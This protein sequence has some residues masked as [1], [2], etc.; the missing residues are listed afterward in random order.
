MSDDDN[1]KN[2]VDVVV[3]L[4]NN[5]K[6]ATAAIASILSQIFPVR[7]VIIVD[8]GSSDRSA[9]IVEQ[10]FAHEPR[11]KLVR[12]EHRGA[13]ATRNRGIA[14]SDAEFIAF[15][16][17]DDL[18]DPL[19]LELQMAVL[20]HN[21][22]V[23]CVYCDYRIMDENGNIVSDAYVL[24]PTLQGDVFSRL[25]TGNLLSGS[26]SAIVVRRSL[27]RRTGLFD[28]SLA[29]AE[30]WDMWLRL[31]K[32]SEIRFV[33]RPLTFIRVH[34]SQMQANA[35]K[36]R[37]AQRMHRLI[38]HLRIWSKWPD[39]VSQHD[40]VLGM[41]R[42]AFLKPCLTTGQS[43][44]RRLAVLR[45]MNIRTGAYIHRRVFR[46]AFKSMFHLYAEIASGHT[47]L[48]LAKARPAEVGPILFAFRHYLS[49]TL[50]RLWPL[51]RKSSASAGLRQNEGVITGV[52][53]VSVIMAVYNGA[54]FVRA[55]IDSIL[56]QTFTDFELIVVDDG[57]TDT[58]AQILKSIGDPRLRLVRQENQGLAA[59]LNHAISLAR[60]KYLARHDHDDVSLPQ[61]FAKQVAFLD[62]HP[63]YAL[64]G[65]H[66]VIW[67]GDQPTDRG[68]HHP[69]D[70]PA[71]RFQLLFDSYFVHGSV[72]L[73]REAVVALGGYTLD[74]SRQPPEDYELWSRIVRH[75]KVAN[76]A[77]PLL[78][79]REVP[80]SISRTVNFKDK[81]IT[82]SSENLA[83]AAGLPHPNS[84]TQDIAAIVHHEPC[85]LSGCPNFARMSNIIRQAAR[86]IDQVA[87]GGDVM[88]R[89]ETLIDQLKGKWPRQDEAKPRSIIRLM[90]GIGNQFFQYLFG[91]SRAATLSEQVLFDAGDCVDMNAVRPFKLSRF[92][93]AGQF[94][95]CSARH[96]DRS[97][98]ELE[99]VTNLEGDALGETIHMPARREVN[100]AVSAE[101]P[102]APGYY[103]GYWQ[104]YK[105]WD[106][107]FDIVSDMLAAATKEVAASRAALYQALSSPDAV[108]VH[109]RRGDYTSAFN[110]EYH[111]VCTAEYYVRAV[112]ELQK[113]LHRPRL[114][115]FGDD[116]PFA[117]EL[118]AAIPDVRY[119]SAEVNDDVDEFLLL[120]QA[121]NLVMS[122]SS[123]SYIAAMNRNA[124]TK[125]VMAPYP[126][127]TFQEDMPDYPQH[128]VRRN[129]KSG[130]SEAEDRALIASARVS[131]IIPSK[132]RDQLLPEAIKTAL[133]QTHEPHEV[134]VSLNGATAAVRS[135]AEVCRQ[136]DGRVKIVEDSRSSLPVARNNG[137]KAATGE[138]LAFLDDDDIWT[139][140]KIER[141]VSAA[142]MMGADVVAC[143]YYKFNEKERWDP[144]SLSSAKT[145]TWSE[146]LTIGN[147]FGGGSSVLARANAIRACGGF[148]EALRSCEDQDMWRRLALSGAALLFID[149][150]L[151]GYRIA[152]D[153]M[154]GD[155]RLMLAG[156][157]AHLSEIIWDSR[158][159]SATASQQATERVLAPLL[160]YLVQLQD[161]QV[162]HFPS[163]EWEIDLIGREFEGNLAAV[164]AELHKLR[165][166]LVSARSELEDTRA[167]LVRTR[168]E[169]DG[170]RAETHCARDELPATGDFADRISTSSPP[171]GRLQSGYWMRTT[172]T[173]HGLWGIAIGL[174]IADPRVFWSLLV[175]RIRHRLLEGASAE[176][177]RARDKLPTD[178]DFLDRILTAP[179]PVGRLQSGYWLKTTETRRGLWGVTIGLAVANPRAFVSLLGRNFRIN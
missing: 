40:E 145:R 118:F 81:V 97:E 165:A 66:T 70:D 56:A 174:A 46:A 127:F 27:F 129:R 9:E 149:D 130:N 123:F 139:R 28:E 177:R 126:W 151:A 150:K 51:K 55:A 68:H 121:P 160:R 102:T 172:G 88:I 115:V 109:I 154:T 8:D 179:A 73:R 107:P 10:Y 101:N 26:A 84:D 173:K 87:P 116:L 47:E 170:T 22:A 90:G 77:E 166:D 64:L 106:R 32:I 95:R 135:V 111:G 163:H 80:S 31:A 44:R 78:I 171:V 120:G 131:V 43:F 108:A 169:F 167:E 41:I 83:Y 112:A 82:I 13:S 143:N 124:R 153:N 5:E 65:T 155:D 2:T 103:D 99:G 39:D 128:W 148:N 17:S 4:Y 132:D 74:K 152:D 168:S 85:M 96:F 125:R 105:Y 23:G 157:L 117:K 63:D 136:K 119:V 147:F 156:A 92:M 38:H 79:Y 15:L 7:K 71:L 61:R 94:V 18:W 45:V 72:M 34:S 93:V 14:Q 89:A 11:V 21:P 37:Y 53:T 49:V 140:D 19:K 20:M 50:P 3:P 1:K 58:T 35:G 161:Q 137:I 114:F 33:D 159:V 134:I 86:R 54:S 62:A 162:N 6:Y 100:F 67:V 48:V 133:D 98:V 42:D 138:W 144:S 24:K 69:T 59:S 76:L 141:Q 176:W 75:H 36:S 12:G 164:C 175:R 30:D 113:S 25:L 52:P 146:A 29:F 60:G 158:S 178:D 122:N 104:S 91:A 142:I 57:S 16:D 110:L